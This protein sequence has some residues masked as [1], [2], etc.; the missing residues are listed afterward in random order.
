MDISSIN[1]LTSSAALAAPNTLPPP[2][3]AD[4][5]ALIQAVKAVNATELFGSENELTFVRDR[6]TNLPA[7]RIINRD[8]GELVAQIPPEI[9]LQMAEELNGNQPAP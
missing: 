4:Q 3:T 1:S 7:V 6:Q 2:A 8:T 5:R 9:L